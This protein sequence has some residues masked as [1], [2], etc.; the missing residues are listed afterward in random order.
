MIE[1]SIR[2]AL[3]GASNF[4]D[5]GGH[6]GADGRRVRHGRVFRSDH[7]ASLTPTD[8]AALQALPLT[9]GIDFRGAAETAA[10]PYRI[11]GVTTLAFSIEPT[12]VQRLRAL[13]ALGQIPS[14]EETVELMCDTYR[15]FVHQHG[16]PSLGSCGTC[17]RIPRL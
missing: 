11:P 7:L 14:T 16:P 12:V 5:L 6:P 17:C 4:R 3:Q 9:H 2:R 8:V 15:S 1:P 13:L 10:L